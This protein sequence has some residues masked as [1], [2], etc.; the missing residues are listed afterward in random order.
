MLAKAVVT[1]STIE[2]AVSG[3]AII[4]FVNEIKNTVA[5]L[6]LEKPEL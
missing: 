6:S 1:M 2:E 4:G 3:F 5:P